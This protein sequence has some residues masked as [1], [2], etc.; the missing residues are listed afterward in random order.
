MKIKSGYMLRKF[1]D[2][3]VAVSISDLDDTYNGLITVNQ[4]GAFLWNLLSSNDY[5]LDELVNSM[6]ETYN[7][8]KKVAKNDINN[9]LNIARS[10]G[11]IDG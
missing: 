10:A 3:Y 4:T 1:G 7:V 2:D 5:I 11:L 9:F 8:N 6:A